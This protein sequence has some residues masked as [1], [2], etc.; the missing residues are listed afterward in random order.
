MTKAKLLYRGFS[1][2]SF[3]WMLFIR[4]AAVV[5]II[6]ALPHYNE[7]PI[8]ILIVTIFCAL[9][10]VF[11]GDDQIDVY[12]DRVELSTNSFASF[13]FKSKDKTYYI[14]DIKRAY[15]PSSKISAV[16]FTLVMIVKIFAPRRRSGNRT[17]PIYLE[18]L[19][20]KEEKIDTSLDEDKRK[21]IVEV[22]NSLCNYD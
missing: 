4:L 19:T 8:A 9:A 7:N 11:F 17:D 13:I 12:E 22:I 6:L 5:I 21:R 1:F 10:I 18:M 20:A 14:K 2:M 15:L 3:L 16:D